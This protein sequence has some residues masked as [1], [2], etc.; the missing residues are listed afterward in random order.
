MGRQCGNKL[1]SATSSVPEGVK[2]GLPLFSLS[3]WLRLLDRRSN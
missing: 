3:I 1:Q 2:I